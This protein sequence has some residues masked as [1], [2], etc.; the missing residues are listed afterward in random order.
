MDLNSTIF[1][2]IRLAEKA[3]KVIKSCKSIS[4]LDTA[5]RYCAQY[6]K[7]T[8]DYETYWDLCDMIKVAERELAA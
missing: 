5:R 1:Y 6:L 8:G 2:Y 7:A 4:Q 3:Q